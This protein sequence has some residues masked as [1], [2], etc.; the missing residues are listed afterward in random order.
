MV[1]LMFERKGPYE[2]IM[3]DRNGRLLGAIAVASFWWKYDR[4]CE[5]LNGW[6]FVG[7][8]GRKEGVLLPISLFDS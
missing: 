5:E 8:T 3:V 7:K 4:N 2:F 6:L 1:L